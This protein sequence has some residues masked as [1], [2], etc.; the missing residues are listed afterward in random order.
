[1][2][3][4]A[5]SQTPDARATALTRIGSALGLVSVMA[6]RHGAQDARH[7]FEAAGGEPFKIARVARHVSHGDDGSLY[8]S[9]RRVSSHGTAEQTEQV[10]RT[11]RPAKTHPNLFAFDGGPVDAFEPR[12]THDIAGAVAQVAEAL[13]QVGRQESPD[14]VLGNRV[15]VTGDGKLAAEDLFVDLE[16]VVGKEG[17]VARKQL[18][19]EDAESPPVGGGAVTGRRDDFGSEVFG[20][21]AKREG[22]ILHVFGLPGI[23]TASQPLLSRLQIIA[24]R[25]TKPKSVTL[26]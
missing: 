1:M 24:P 10:A 22:P 11:G 18:E 23:V 15:N 5:T 21:A 8:T 12:V 26:M 3:E 2:S 14:Q 20:R 4:F 25:L 16:R 19:Q 17:R 9:P 7:G 13:R 6:L